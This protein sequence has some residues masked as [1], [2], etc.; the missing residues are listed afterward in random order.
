MWK[1]GTGATHCVFSAALG[2]SG[3]KITGEV[4]SRTSIIVVVQATLHRHYSVCASRC[5]GPVARRVTSRNVEVG[6]RC[7]PLCLFRGS[8]RQWHKDYRGS[9]EPH[10]HYSVCAGHFAQTL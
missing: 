1:W 6:H 10:K 2:A 7:Y 4:L 9:A 5:C 8:R 3:T